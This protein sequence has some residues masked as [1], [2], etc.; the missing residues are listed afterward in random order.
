MIDE[1]KSPL[2]ANLFNFTL[3]DTTKGHLKGI[4][5]WTKITAILAFVSIGVSLLTIVITVVNFS[6]YGLGGTI[7]G[8]VIVW[9]LSIL[10][11]VLLYNSSANIQ[12]ALA[13]TDQQQLNKGLF[14]MARYFKIIGILF[15]VAI[16]L[17]ILAFLFYLSYAGS[18]GF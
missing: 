9:V 2:K 8:Q 11:N 18:R 16:I 5:Q 7:T 14:Q 3:D 17:V 4:A 13:T 12:K 15:I 1:D 10:L 6:T